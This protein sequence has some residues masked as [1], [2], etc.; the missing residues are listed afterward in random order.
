MVMSSRRKLMG[1]EMSAGHHRSREL[2]SVEVQLQPSAL[3][4]GKPCR[5]RLQRTTGTCCFWFGQTRWESCWQ[6]F[7]T[8]S[9]QP[10]TGNTR[11]AQNSRNTMGIY[12]SQCQ[13]VT[14]KKINGFPK[15]DSTRI[16]LF[17]SLHFLQGTWS[18]ALEGLHIHTKPGTILRV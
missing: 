2:R 11:D 3:R 14:W 12:T 17:S 4:Y 1:T 16:H 5:K 9:P 8:S 10:K 6:C 7:D 15:N 18:S 13:R